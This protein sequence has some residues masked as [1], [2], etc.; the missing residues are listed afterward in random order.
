VSGVRPAFCLPTTTPITTDDT[1]VPGETVYVI[2][3]ERL[4]AGVE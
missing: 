2:D 4:A 3:Y 1:I